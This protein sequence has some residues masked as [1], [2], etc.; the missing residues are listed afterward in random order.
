LPI[1]LLLLVALQPFY[2]AQAGEA[3]R[4][5]VLSSED[6]AHPAHGLTDQGIG[7]S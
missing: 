4:V 5:L 6:K 3:K 2:P 1:I 7:A